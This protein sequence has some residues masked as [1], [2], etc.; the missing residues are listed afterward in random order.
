LATNG[1]LVLP[2]F[3]LYIQAMRAIH[4]HISG[5]LFYSFLQHVNHFFP[6]HTFAVHGWASAQILFWWLYVVGTY[7]H[8]YVAVVESTREMNFPRH[9]T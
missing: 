3:P 9:P 8:R 2:K 6:P 4:T 5:H 7:V 1:V